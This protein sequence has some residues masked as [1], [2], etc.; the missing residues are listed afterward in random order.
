MRILVIGSGGREHALCW[1]LAQSS[2]MTTLFACPGNPGMAA[3]A[4][5]VPGSDYLAVANALHPHLS[6]VGPEAPRSEGIVDR[7]RERGWNI[8]GPTASAARL[9][10]SKAFAK[11][12]M[13]EA[14]IPT[15]RHITVDGETE[16][17][18]AL[19][20]FP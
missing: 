19:R 1:K 4:T 16:A 3:L 7:F 17:V 2:E 6:I 14:G 12:V 5:C 20:Q 11:S 18:A 15:A 10:A 9:E 8:I 13:Q